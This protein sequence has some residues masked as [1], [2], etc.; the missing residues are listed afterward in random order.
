MMRKIFLLVL[1]ILLLLL[2]L[3]WP[4]HRAPAPVAN[5]LSCVEHAEQMVATWKSEGKDAAAIEKLFQAEIAKCSGV[6]ESCAAMTGA[7]NADLA[8]LG[9]AL[10]SG[11]MPPP[12][13]LAR[14]HDRTSKMR[15]FSGKPSVCM[16]Y[17]K[18]DTDGDLIPDDQ[19]NCPN[20][21]SLAPTDS[22]G[23]PDTS[24]L[25]AAPSP[26]AIQLATKALN[27]PLS[28]ACID[29]PL[30]QRGAVL[31]AGIA[32]DDESFLFVVS[33]AANQPVNCQV[34]YEVDIRIRNVS[35]FQGRNTTTLYH[36]VFRPAD[37]LTGTLARSTGMTFRLS[38][39]DTKVPWNNLTFQTIE[40]G[41]ISERY[42]RVRTVN[43]NGFTEGWGAF[44]LVPSTRFP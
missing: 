5:V 30:P 15:S 9:R 4:Q 17:A 10:L 1:A 43:G 7:I 18:G 6:T 28:K 27:I 32:P 19:D 33:R 24:P 11:S 42:F 36:K 16:A 21:P 39:E 35:F 41:E 26:E 12:E 37:A 34:F 20:T 22:H 44:T 13:Y 23:C 31:K 25:P 2:W 14:V 40:P 3:F 8:W 29:A 38:K